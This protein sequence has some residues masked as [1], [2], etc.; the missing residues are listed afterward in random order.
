MTAATAAALT[1]GWTLVVEVDRLIPGRG[2]R[3]LV[4]G[5]PVAVFLA[6]DGT[7]HAVGDIDPRSGAS[8]MA[9]GL[10]GSTS[11]GGRVV[12]FVASP[13]RKERYALDDGRALAG[14]GAGLGSWE[15][16]TVDGWV[17]VGAPR[18]GPSSGGNHHETN[19]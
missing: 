19:R 9:R 15:V 3:A 2:V 11:L 1:T 14:D 18:V 12:R 8:V 17:L 4:G 13:L 5:A 6:D 16:R 10:T 7:V